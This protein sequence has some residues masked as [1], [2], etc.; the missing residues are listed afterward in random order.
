MLHLWQSR[1][2]QLI[3]FQGK[4]QDFWNQCLTIFTLSSQATS[5][6]Y[7]NNEHEEWLCDMKSFCEQCNL[8]LEE[9]GLESSYQEIQQGTDQIDK[10]SNLRRISEN[11]VYMSEIDS[12]MFKDD[13]FQV[14]LLARQLLKKIGNHPS[15]KF[16]G[17]CTRAPFFEKPL[18]MAISLAVEHQLA[19]RGM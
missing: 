11:C 13:I 18:C 3:G 12:I 2:E 8:Y 16:N 5:K 14:Q 6:M 10:F 15:T 17:R 9:Y 1:K 4:R 7:V 19:I